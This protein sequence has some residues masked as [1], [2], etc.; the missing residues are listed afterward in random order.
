MGESSLAMLSSFLNGKLIDSYNCDLQL[1]A[2]HLIPLGAL[3]IEF[4]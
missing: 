2:V 3:Y 1:Y 4:T